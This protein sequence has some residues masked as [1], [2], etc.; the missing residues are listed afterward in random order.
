MKK[1][2]CILDDLEREACKAAGVT[3]SNN[4]AAFVTSAGHVVGVDIPNWYHV[5][6]TSAHNGERA[7]DA[8][9]RVN[10]IYGAG[11]LCRLER[12]LSLECDLYAADLHD[13][14]ARVI[15]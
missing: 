14:Y 5:A 13:G 6:I 12:L 7:Y 8:F 10:N 1:P 15:V 9:E 11:E 2:A 4:E 3:I